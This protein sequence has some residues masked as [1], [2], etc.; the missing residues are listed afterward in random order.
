VVYPGRRVLDVLSE[1]LD[2]NSTRPTAEQHARLIKFAR[3]RY[4]AG[5]SLREIAELTGRTQT[6]IRRALDQAGVPRRPRGA[7]TI[8]PPV[9]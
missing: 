3:E 2:S 8:N 5:R 9:D 7:P 6:A 4:R 1:F